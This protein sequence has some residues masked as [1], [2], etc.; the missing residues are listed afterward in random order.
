MAQWQDLLKLDSVLQNQVRQL[1]EGRFPKEIRH[2]ACYWIESQ[3][4]D[5]AAANENAART[6]FNS[7]L[8][9][10]EEQW[11]CS[12]QE[13]NIL[14]APDY[15]SMKD[16]L[17]QQFQD[18]CVNLARI[19][20]D[21]LKWEKEILDSVAATQ[22]CN[23]QS[24]MPQT[25]RDMDSKVSELKSKISELKKEI[26]MQ[27]GLNEKLDYIQKTWQN[28][29][30]QII[31]LAQIKPGLMEEECLKQAMFITQEKQTLLQQ[32]VELLNQTAETV[33][34]LIDVKLREWKYRQKL[35]CI[36]GPVDTSLELLQKWI[37]AVAEVLLGVRDQ[38]QKLQ[39]QNNKYSST[40]ASNLSASITEI[41]KFVLLLITKLLTK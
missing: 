37:T 6:C 33:A 16:Y 10:L 21:C 8:T 2:W 7:L 38:L 11:N 26:K 9:Y 19:L 39:D 28:K 27:E 23:N 30:E 15:R 41:D 34:T 1:Y 20:S 18:D 3:D 5:S 22:S 13:N 12:V 36:G 40:D 25:W 24:V 32:L 4:W 35:A 17:M 31:E 14:Q 29:V